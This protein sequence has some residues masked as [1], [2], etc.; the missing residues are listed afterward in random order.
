MTV[1]LLRTAFLLVLFSCGCFVEIDGYGQCSDPM[2]NQ[3]YR[4]IFR[5]PPDP[6]APV[7]GMR[8]GRVSPVTG[9]CN[10][11][12]YGGGT[13]GRNLNKLMIWIRAWRVCQDPW[14]AEV[15]A[16]ELPGGP[17][18]INNHNSTLLENGRPF[19]VAGQCNRTNY[20]VWGNFPELVANVKNYLMSGPKANTRPARRTGRR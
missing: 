6:S 9:E 10:P 3:A 8:P 19:S 13:Y 2:I 12:I 5:R 7:N 20:G 11:A 16:T 1:S 4:N 17:H 15:Y 14:I 18:L